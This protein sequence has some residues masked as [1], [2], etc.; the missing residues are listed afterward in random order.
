M[1]YTSLYDF[2][3]RFKALFN[4]E[5]K[6]LDYVLVD[7]SD[8]FQNVADI[9]PELLLGKKISDIVEEN[10]NDTFDMKEIYYDMIPKTRRKFE[11]YVEKLD[12]WYLV[13]MFSEDKDYLILFFND[14][15]RLKKP[16]NMPR[17]PIRHAVK[18]SCP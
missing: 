11:K 6:F 13:N 17:D 10:L 8:N 2:Y 5:G 7:I 9:K 1:E 12:K 16:K 4:D 14:I 15:S 18:D 3:L